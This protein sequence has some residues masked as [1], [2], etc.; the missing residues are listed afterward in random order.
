MSKLPSHITW[1]TVLARADEALAMY[2]SLMN[3]DPEHGI[4]Y[5]QRMARMMYLKIRAMEEMNKES[6]AAS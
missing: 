6:E 5:Q 2:A 3:T 4:F 1:Q